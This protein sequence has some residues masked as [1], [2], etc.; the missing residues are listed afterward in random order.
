MAVWIQLIARRAVL[1]GAVLAVLGVLAAG[2]DRS[3][4]SAKRAPGPLRVV[5]TVAPLSGLVRP[6]LPADAV[7][8]TLIPPGRSEHGYELSPK[9]MADL[10]AADVVVYVGLGLDPQVES[11]LKKKQVPTRRVVSFSQVAGIDDPLADGHHDHD[12]HEGHDHGSLDPHLWL[13]PELA[14]KLVPAVAAAAQAA[15]MADGAAA[16]DAVQK[17]RTSRDALL[18]DIKALDAELR[19]KLAPLAGMSIVTHH[20]AWERFAGRYGL[21]VAAVIR[22]INDSE[23]SIGQMSDAVQAIKAQGVRAVFVEPQFNAAAAERVAKEAG[24]KLGTLDPLGDGDWFK[25]MRDN[26]DALVRFLGD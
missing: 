1:M 10:A 8:T 9:D 26:A 20:A 18:A 21:K 24:V 17:V 6:L 22:T 12:D 19:A 13:D 3:G 2:C 15:L 7:V 14:A 11:L 5:V 4:A 23:P 16:A 25:L